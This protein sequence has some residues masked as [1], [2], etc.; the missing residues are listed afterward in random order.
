MTKEQL[1]FKGVSEIVGA[2]GLGLLILT[3]E[4]KER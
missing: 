4:V 3:D 1:F 2:E